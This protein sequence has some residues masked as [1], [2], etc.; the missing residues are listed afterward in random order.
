MNIVHDNKGIRVSWPRL[1]RRAAAALMMVELAI[2]LLGAQDLA[3]ANPWENYCAGYYDPEQLYPPLASQGVL[4]DV[5]LA[6]YLHEDR[7]VADLDGCCYRIN[8][9]LRLG[10]GEGEQTLIEFDL[11]DHEGAKVFV[12]DDQEGLVDVVEV[13][14]SSFEYVVHDHERF[15]FEVA[16]P[17]Q[18]LPT[19]PV[20]VIKTS[21]PDPDDP[22]D[23]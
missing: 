4:S 2:G 22:D 5:E 11:P 17:V 19:E 23:P 10:L 1:P 7:A 8:G 12:T 9:Q 15:G 20:I 21:N 3:R 18:E 16:P 6:I 14:G 13:D